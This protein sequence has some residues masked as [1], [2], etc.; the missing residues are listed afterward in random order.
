MT[1]T[2]DK[3]RQE[4]SILKKNC[5]KLILGIYVIS[6]SSLA[7]GWYPENRNCNIAGTAADIKD[8]TENLCVMEE[9]RNL[10]RQGVRETGADERNAGEHTDEICRRT[11][12]AVKKEIKYHVRGVTMDEKDCRILERI[13]EAEA[14]DQ[15]IKGRILVANVI[16]NR[17]RSEEFPDTVRGVVFE[18][19]QFSPVS[20]GSYYRV[21]VSDKTKKAVKR[22]IRGEDYS[23]GAL[24]FMYRAGSSASNVAWFDRDLNRL[25]RYGCHE[26]F[27]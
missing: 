18:P 14:G 3:D 1:Y 25:F 15:S 2:S 19:R 21:K 5:V 7:L 13:I 23:E 22:M 12:K 10:F 8:L 20:N 11:A 16:L 27:A 9:N 17:I 24:Y 4:V 26:F 6:L